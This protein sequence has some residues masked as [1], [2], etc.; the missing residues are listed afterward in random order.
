MFTFDKTGF[1]EIV[2]KHMAIS[3]NGPIFEDCFTI[4]VVEWVDVTLLGHY[5][6]VTNL[7]ICV[8]LMLFTHTMV[9]K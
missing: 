4:N 6:G 7:G 2:S 9:H 8:E 3:S 5:S 1:C